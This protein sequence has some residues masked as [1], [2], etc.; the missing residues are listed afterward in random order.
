MIPFNMPPVV[1]TGITYMQAAIE[2]GKICGD[3][4]FTK[5]CNAWIER[6]A[7]VSR[8]LLTTS[9]THALEMAALLCNLN[10]GDE[11]I[12]PSYTFSSTANAFVLC[13][14][15]LVFVDIRPDTMNIDDTKIEAAITNRTKVICVVHYAGV[16]CEMDKIMDIAA[17]YQLLVV[18]DAAQAIMST[19]KG[20]PLGSIGDFGCYSFHETKNYSMGEGGALLLRDSKYIERAE[21]LREKG[22][23]RSRFFR[24]QVDKYTW[25]DYGSSYLPS[26]MNAA[27]LWAQ[28]ECANEINERRLKIWR[29]YRDAFLDLEQHKLIKLPTIPAH[30]QHNAHM[31]YIKCKDIKQRSELI[32]FLKAN[33]ILS[34]FHYVPLHSADAGKKY[35]RFFGEDVY[36]TKESECL[37]RLPLYMQLSDD[38]CNTV[39]QAVHEFYRCG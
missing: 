27:Y 19:Y 2:S 30:C 32:D 10:S 33:D 25:V 18:E 8:A 36:T 29:H 26:D 1:K 13:G 24:G 3:G 21:I 14:A 34:V 20:K 7:G 35:G 28:F 38:D 22:T 39:I 11:V 16:A 17:R 37:V 5:L 12:L 31:F 9:G 15:R 23:D 6:Q 4:Q